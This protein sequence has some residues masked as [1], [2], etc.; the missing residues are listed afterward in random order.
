MENLKSVDAK[1]D[2]DRGEPFFHWEDGGRHQSSNFC[3][4]V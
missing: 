3:I 1:K 2:M 4:W